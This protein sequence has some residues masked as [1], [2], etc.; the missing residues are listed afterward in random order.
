M[1]DGWRWICMCLVWS[2]SDGG[3]NSCVIYNHRVNGYTQQSTGL[4]MIVGD[5]TRGHCRW[6][7]HY[8]GEYS[9]INW[10]RT[11]ILQGQG[12]M[13]I[14]TLSGWLGILQQ[15]TWQARGISQGDDEITDVGKIQR[16]IP[17][18]RGKQVSE[19]AKAIGGQCSMI[20]RHAVLSM[21]LKY[22]W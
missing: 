7:N 6:F 11:G 2:K 18:G 21:N 8:C 5:V 17:Q 20:H 14:Q 22:I 9:T 15:S 10:T 19:T 1:D 12:M 16:G 13:R 3:T 4:L